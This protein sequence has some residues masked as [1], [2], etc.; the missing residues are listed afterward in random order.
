MVV[1]DSELLA[2]SGPKDSVTEATPVGLATTVR[3]AETRKAAARQVVLS[4][5][6]PTLGEVELTVVCTGHQRTADGISRLP[7]KM[8]LS[9]VQDT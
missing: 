6:Q 8:A 2:D 4:G 5:P 7:P 9:I 3:G 1:E